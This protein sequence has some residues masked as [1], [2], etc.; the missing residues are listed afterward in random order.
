MGIAICNMWVIT[1]EYEKNGQY[2]KKIS[3]CVEKNIQK[4]KK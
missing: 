2:L 4:M 1:S 3:F